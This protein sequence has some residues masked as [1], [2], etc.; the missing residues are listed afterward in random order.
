MSGAR[1]NHSGKRKMVHAIRKRERE[2]RRWEEEGERSVWQNLAMLGALGWLIVIPTLVGLAVGRWLD[3]T[4]ETG[5][6]LTAA[7]I[8]LGVC[9][10]G[11]L[12]WQRMNKA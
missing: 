7:G 3:R 4:F 6:T 9:A 10:G 11:V 8:F 5:I 2:R 1:P 12:A